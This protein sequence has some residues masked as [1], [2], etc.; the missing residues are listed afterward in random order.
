[1][2]T[3]LRRFGFESLFAG[4]CVRDRLLGIEPREYDIATS[5]TPEEVKRVF[6]RAIGVGESFGVM[7]LRSGGI[8]FEI[9]T[10]RTDGGY[11]DGRHPT[12]VRFAGAEEDAKRRDFSINGLFERPESGE[13]VDFVGG[14]ADLEARLLRAIGDPAARLAEDRLRALRAVRFAARFE[15]TVDPATEAA[16]LALDGELLGVSRERLGQELRRMFASPHR[17]TAA[18]LLERWSLDRVLLGTHGLAEKLTRLG[19]LPPDA[20][21]MASLAAW[22]LD[23]AEATDPSATAE[24]LQDGL[25]LSNAERE[26]L[27]AVLRSVVSLRAEWARAGIARRRRFGMEPGFDPAVIIREAEA[28]GEGR[29]ATAFL[30]G[31][32]PERSPDRLVR[33]R[34]LIDAGFVPGPRFGDLLEAVYDAQLEG[35]VHSRGE[36]MAFVARLDLGSGPSRNP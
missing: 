7:L 35:R 26:E 9:A 25:G 34:D 31:F 15:L 16:I 10:F 33:G 18:A 24:R 12:E 4:G 5:A 30:E 6:P 28:P 13:V 11:V 20:S 1:V 8:T 3:R 19:A 14:R 2:A 32:G 27:A 22:L 23:R 36:A 29:S 17:A 21:A